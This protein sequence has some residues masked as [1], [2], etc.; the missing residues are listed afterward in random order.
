MTLDSLL[1]DEEELETTDESI[2]WN[3][4]LACAGIGLVLGIPLSRVTGNNALTG[5]LIFGGGAI[6]WAIYYI[7]VQLRKKR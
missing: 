5:L 6:G 4:S 7:S 3:I 1:R 2:C